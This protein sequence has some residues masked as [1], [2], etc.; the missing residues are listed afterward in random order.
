M[1]EQYYLPVLKYISENSI[2]KPFPNI[3]GVPNQFIDSI[4]L[5]FENEGYIKSFVSGGFVITE[6]GKIFISDSESNVKHIK[7]EPSIHIGHNINAPVSHSDFS[8]KTDNS[9]NIEKSIKN[10]AHEKIKR[11]PIEILYWCAG[12]VIGLIAIYELF[13]KLKLISF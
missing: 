5:N 9:L 3:N 12:I 13:H 11:S 8:N 7:N 4:I 10:K 1:I 2:S 6:S